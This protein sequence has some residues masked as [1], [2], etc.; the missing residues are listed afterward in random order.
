MFPAGGCE[1]EFF[2]DSF[3]VLENFVFGSCRNNFHIE[4][5]RLTCREFFTELQFR[6][7]PVLLRGGEMLPQDSSSPRVCFSRSNSIVPDSLTPRRDGFSSR[8]SG[9]LHP[10]TGC[11]RYQS[12]R[13]QPVLRDCR[14]RWDV[15]LSR[16]K[17]RRGDVEGLPNNLYDTSI[18]SPSAAADTVV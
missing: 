18:N 14:I 12:N 4:I 10:A 8:E 6:V 1:W 15:D 2:C 3:C 13:K 11:F 7:F 9:S 5:F 17:V 16:K